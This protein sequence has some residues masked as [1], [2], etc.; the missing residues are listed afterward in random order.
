MFSNAP[1]AFCI[2]DIAISLAKIYHLVVASLHG[3]AFEEYTDPDNQEYI[4]DYYKTYNNDRFVKWL[5]L[6][7]NANIKKII[8]DFN[9]GFILS[10]ADKR[11]FVDVS[12]FLAFRS[13]FIQY[14]P[15][16]ASESLAS[17]ELT[18]LYHFIA[19]RK[20]NPIYT[21]ILTYLNRNAN[22]LIWPAILWEQQTET[23]RSKEKYALFSNNILMRTIDDITA[24]LPALEDFRNENSFFYDMPGKKQI[25]A[26]LKMIA[27][28]KDRTLEDFIFTLR[29]TVDS[30]IDILNKPPR[31]EDARI[32][33][34]LRET[35]S[36]IKHILQEAALRLEVISYIYDPNKSSGDENTFIVKFMP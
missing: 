12:A 31:F 13:I 34:S 3:H 24:E 6:S 9:E 8:D 14:N 2:Q 5:S 26:I 18:N 23:T 32:I 29:Q 27:T 15:L 20:H 7:H 22:H 11:G 19:D 30:Q 16:G 25:K 1:K 33:V 17:G 4:Q 21:K 36:K 28:R 10:L 35:F